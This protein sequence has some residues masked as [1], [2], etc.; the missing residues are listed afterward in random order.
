MAP[1][2]YPNRMELCGLFVP[3]RRLCADDCGGGL[4]PPQWLR[5]ASD[6]LQGL[7]QFSLVFF[8]RQ[9]SHM[10]AI[11]HGG[12]RTGVSP[13]RTG[14]RD[15][16]RSPWNGASPHRARVAWR[17]PR[18]FLGRPVLASR[19]SLTR[20]TFCTAAVRIDELNDTATHC[21][22]LVAAGSI[23]R[24]VG[25]AARFPVRR[26][27]PSRL[28]LIVVNIPRC[29]RD[30]PRAYHGGIQAGEPRAVRRS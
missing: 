12:P 22:R 21:N 13:H 27:G 14:G 6:R 17:A 9:T 11:R 29:G 3:L 25:C 26:S 18:A 1:R 16:W 24:A 20:E 30:G 7:D 19:S 5:N 23:L 15:P 4:L 28:Q 8:S 10:E 2:L